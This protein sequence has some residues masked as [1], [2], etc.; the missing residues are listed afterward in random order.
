MFKFFEWQ[1]LKFQTKTLNDPKRSMKVHSNNFILHPQYDRSKL[2]N[3]IG[4]IRLPEP[5]DSPDVKFLHLPDPSKSYENYDGLMPGVGLYQPYEKSNVVRYFTAT[6]VN[7]QQ[8]HN[9]W[10]AFDYTL[11]EKSICA[12]DP[13]H[14]STSCKGDSGSPLVI[15]VNKTYVVIGLIS[16]SHSG[17]VAGVPFVYTRVGAHNQ[18][19]TNTINGRY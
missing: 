5:M 6:V 1:T 13:K 15:R 3:D 10:E 17:C 2:E 4:L 12:I 8:C 18:W 9:A 7:L 11:D 14:V 19:I 16:W